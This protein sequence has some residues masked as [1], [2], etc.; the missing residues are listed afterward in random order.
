[1]EDHDG[2]YGGERSVAICNHCSRN[3]VCDIRVLCG[4]C[5]YYSC[6][7]CD[8]VDCS[9]N[10]SDCTF[11]SDECADCGFYEQCDNVVHHDRCEECGKAIDNPDDE[12]SYSIGHM[13]T[14]CLMANEDV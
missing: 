5:D 7:E 3:D 10:A 2:C 4:G 13:C 14:D 11:P 9:D 12:E 6:R 1:M 8:D